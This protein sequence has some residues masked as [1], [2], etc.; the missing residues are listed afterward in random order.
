M[1]VQEIEV[2]P[3]RRT[4]A[5]LI[6]FIDK[7]NVN[8]GELVDRALLLRVFDAFRTI[9]AT[10]FKARTER[11]R[12]EL[13]LTVK[14]KTFKGKGADFECALLHVSDKLDCSQMS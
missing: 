6:Q 13:E 3:S 5:Q 14:G 4:V 1:T 9:E 11:R 10:A 8:N 12:W 7:H 2:R